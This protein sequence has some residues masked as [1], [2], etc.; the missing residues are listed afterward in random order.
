MLTTIL[1]FTA[2]ILS[3]LSLVLHAVAPHTKSHLDDRAAEIVDE[4]LAKV[5]E[6]EP[7]A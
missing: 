7:K 2:T 4:V 1:A 5:K 6:A 3:A